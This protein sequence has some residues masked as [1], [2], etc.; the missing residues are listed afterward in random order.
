MPRT[1]ES[2]TGAAGGGAG[3]EERVP[4]LVRRIPWWAWVLAVAVLVT[5][6][7]AAL[8]G[9]RDVPIEKI[10]TIE[11]REPHL[12]GQL[13]TTVTRIYLSSV[14]PASGYEPDDGEQYVVV[15][16]TVDNTTAEPSIFGRDLLRIVVDGVVEPDVAPDGVYFARQGVV[17]DFLQPGVQADMIFTWPVPEGTVAPGD[18]AIIGIFEQFQVL[19]DPVF[20]DTA[21]G[22]PTP[23]ARILTTIEGR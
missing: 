21:Y 11:L 13:T 5:G 20:G 2:G 3:G 17:L 12:G 1:A 18:D 6:L 7:I 9:F 8:G 22:S 14:Q 4:A 10:P 23:T 19:D 16:A 15:E